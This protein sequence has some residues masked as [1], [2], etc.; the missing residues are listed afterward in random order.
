LRLGLF[1]DAA[2]RR[3]V[4]SGR[5]WSGEEVLGFTSFAAAVGDRLGGLVLIARRTEETETTPFEL[6]DGVE[7]A[8]LPYYRSLRDIPQLLRAMPGTLVA[9]WKALSRVDSV[10]VSAPNPVGL[11][12]MALAA[13]RRRRILILVRQDT[14]RY[15]RSRLPSPLWA[16]LL[17]PLWLVDRIFRAVARKARTVVVGAQIAKQYRAPRDNVLETTVNLISEVDIPAQAPDREW[18]APVRLLTVGRIEPEKNPLLLVDVLA[19]LEREWPGRFVATWV[20][21]GR[22]AE[23]MRERAEVLGVS[24]S[25]ELPGF[26]PLEPQLLDR[27]RGADAFVHISWTEG[28]PG[29]IIEALASGLPTVATDVGGIR[30]AVEDGHAALLVPPGDEGALTDAIL[31]L[32]DDPPLRHRLAKAGLGL[33]R[34]HSLEAEADRVAAFISGS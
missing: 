26:V 16:P 19:R 5:V 9:L 1:V 31:R 25:L 17:V 33:A 15:F 18:S 32:D 27:Y 13:V 6:P 28:V 3:D 2:F 22:L 34:Q 10:W 21:T 23:A 11:M 12:V 4:S 30:S 20:G 8:P 24:E 29:V 7:L 14:M